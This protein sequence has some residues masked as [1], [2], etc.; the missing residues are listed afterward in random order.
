PPGEQRWQSVTRHVCRPIRSVA[1]FGHRQ[2]RPDEQ[3]SSPTVLSRLSR[4]SG[5]RLEIRGEIPQVGRAA[6]RS[7]PRVREVEPDRNAEV[8]RHRNRAPELVVAIV[9]T[10]D[11][12]LPNHVHAA[13]GGASMEAK[14][15]RER[16]VE[17][18]TDP[19]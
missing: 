15:V 16:H 10:E 12:V 4:K 13:S 17:I 14:E 9:P 19:V 8:G 6:A 3:A 1:T 2:Y 5:K 18:S 11:D 7:P